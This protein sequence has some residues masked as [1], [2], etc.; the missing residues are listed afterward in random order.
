MNK[1]DKIYVA[2]HLGMVGSAIVRRLKKDGYEN[3]VF[4]S[5]TEL[6]LKNYNDVEEFFQNEKPN[7]V[8][9]AAAIVGGIQANIDYPATFLIDNLMIQNNIIHLSYKYGVKK[10]LFLGSSCVYPRLCKQPMKEE[11][12]LTGP[13]EP[14]NE[15]YALA[16][17]TGL[18]L[19]EYYNRQYRTDFISV[20]PCNLYGYNDN[21]N[22]VT[23]H[24]LAASILRVHTAMKNNDPYITIWGDGSARREFMFVDDVADAILFLMEKFSDLKHINIGVGYDVSITELHEII[25]EVLG[26]KGYIKFDMKRPNGMPQKLLDVTKLH[27]LGWNHKVDLRE[28]ISRTYEWYKREYLGIEG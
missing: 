9:L 3:L 28:G 23:S 4:R 10:L 25:S 22:L 1:R 2:G 16:K 20:M 7:Y 6:D 14:T 8:F 18:K 11:Y 17:I 12:L 5:I 15:A 21:F 26:Y 24:V 13:L 19:I 27:N